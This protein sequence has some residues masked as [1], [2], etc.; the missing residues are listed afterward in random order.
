MPSPDQDRSERLA[1][2]KSIAQ[3]ERQEFPTLDEGAFTTM[4]ANL[5]ESERKSSKWRRLGWVLI[6]IVG[7]AVVAAIAWGLR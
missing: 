5:D 6:A 1:R 2:L 4:L 3:D 7:L